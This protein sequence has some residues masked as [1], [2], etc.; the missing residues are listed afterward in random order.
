[1]ASAVP[2]P[3]VV[4]LGAT[5]AQGGSVL[6]HL[7]KSG[8]FRVRAVTRKLGD[9]KAK[10]LAAQGVEVV[11]GDMYNKASLVKAFNGAWGLFAMTQFWEPDVMKSD[12]K[13]EFQSGKNTVEAAVEAKVQFVVASVLDDVEKIS[14]GRISVPHFTEKARVEE[15]WRKSGIA[16]AFVGL[17]CYLENFGTFFNPKAASDGVM[18]FHAPMRHDAAVGWVSVG[19]TGLVV[20]TLFEN[21]K[22]WAGK[23]V[24]LSSGYW[25]WSQI[26]EIWGRVNG[27]PARYVKLPYEVF[28]TFAGAE[29]TNMFQ[30]FSEYGIFNGRDLTDTRKR[31]PGLKDPEWY[32]REKTI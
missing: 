30:Y 4:V 2:Q 24:D 28:K 12:G 17:G 23:S 18:E 31:W 3:V 20:R 7:L 11:E 16:S 10:K 22:E 1:M 29:I 6:R 14:G 25:T 8:K 13:L 9:D 19:D 26:A 15:L 5:G 27:K 21:P 32:F